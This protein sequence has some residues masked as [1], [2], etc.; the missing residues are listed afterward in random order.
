MPGAAAATAA[1][2]AAGSAGVEP[3]APLGKDTPIAL[4]FSAR[5][6]CAN[7]R[8]RCESRV[9]ASNGFEVGHSSVPES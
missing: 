2:F 8:I 9:Q 5:P 4:A 3:A 6:V 7:K 1:F